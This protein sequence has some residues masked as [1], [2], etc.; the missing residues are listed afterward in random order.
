MTEWL[1]VV[2]TDLDDCSPQVLGYVAERLLA[3]GA[4]DAVLLPL[5][6]KKGRPGVRLEALVE[7]RLLGAI[8][9]IILSE[10][11]ALGLRRHLVERTVLQREIVKVKTSVGPIR[12]K[13]SR[14]IAKAMPEYEDCRRAASRTGKPL[15]EVQAMALRALR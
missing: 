15:R 10:T 3:A 1:W 2:Q 5:Q 9:G 4:R 6:M 11:P 13:R 8:E 7:D 12:V 14:G